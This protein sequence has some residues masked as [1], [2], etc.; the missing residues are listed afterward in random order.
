MA[1][2]PSSDHL[3]HWADHTASKIIR[4]KGDKD[5][6]VCASGITP[7]GT[8]H[9]GNFREVITVDFVVRALKD[10]GK[11]AK[12]IFSWD[13]FDTLR[14]IPA[15]LP[16]Q[17]MLKEHLFWPIVD[18]ADPH[19]TEESYARFHETNF[20]KQIQKVGIRPL[21]LFQAEKYRS[22][23]YNALIK[24]ALQ[25]TSTIKDI[26]NEHRTTPLPDHWLPVSVYCG[27]C[28]RDRMKNITFDGNDTIHYEC[29]LC[30]HKGEENI[31]TSKSVKLPWRIDWPMRWAFEKVDFEPGGK[32][33]SSE[34]GSFTTAKEVVKKIFSFTAPTYLQYDFVSI[35]GLGGK[36]SS[37]SGNLVTVD[38]VLR[39]YEPEMVRY[40]FASYKPNIDF[41]I[42]FDLNVIKVYEDFDRLERVAY[43]KEMANPKKTNMAKRVYE[44]S[45]LDGVIP[46]ECPF[47]PAFRH[48]C[49]ILQIYNGDIDKA[50]QFYEDDIKNDRDER[51]FQE[52][53]RCALNWIADHAPEDFKFQINHECPQDIVKNL[54][55]KQKTFLSKT[56]E[57]ISKKFSSIKTDKELHE[58]LYKI[59]HEIELEPAKAFVPLY[60]ILIGKEKGPK[61]AGFLRIIG[62]DT[63]IQLLDQF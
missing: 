36:M 20:E 41:A 32:D 31:S 59:I 61:L 43:G 3:V 21:E 63:I 44:L 23:T 47:Q 56:K 22:G 46:K 48:L 24:K 60:Q 54:D 35:K 6:Y 45:Q 39:I 29:E 9:F 33:H 7:S 52:R 4:E 62:Q 2:T 14:K 51:R 49:N 28:H 53:A 10:K 55:E 40:I 17:D 26:L 38:D 58:E 57:L 12:F 42:N 1:G 11:Q 30:N 50:K 37:S 34:G 19:G 15:N 18:V 5:L 16:Q 25:E 13:D 27:N 8:V